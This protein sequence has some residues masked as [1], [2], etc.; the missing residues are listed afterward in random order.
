[1]LH[2][3]HTCPFHVKTVIF[4]D[5]RNGP[6]SVAKILIVQSWFNKEFA[7]YG[8]TDYTDTTSSKKN[9]NIL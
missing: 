3:Q 1:M 2:R 5:T 8:A 9:E 7:I 6:F 4:S